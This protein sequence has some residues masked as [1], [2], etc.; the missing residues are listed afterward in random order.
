MPG[1]DDGV[2][3]EGFLGAG[4]PVGIEESNVGIEDG[5]GLDPRRE[6]LHGEVKEALFPPK[7]R[8]VPWD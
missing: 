4:H 3:P 7:G 1:V 6:V 8:G 2:E 5:H